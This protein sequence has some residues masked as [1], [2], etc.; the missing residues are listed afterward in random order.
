[1]VTAKYL[2]ACAADPALRDVMASADLPEAFAEAWGKYLLPRPMFC[3]ET[4]ARR[5]AGDLA[6]LFRLL[7]SL[8]D[9]LFGGDVRAFCAAL[10]MDERR[11][12][13][14]TRF[15]GEPILYG[16][17]D[18]YR[19]GSDFRLMEFNVGSE[20]GGVDV[21]EI[22][23]ALLATE[24]FRAFAD[25]HG[26]THV[27]TP[28]AI[29]RQFVRATGKDAPVVATLEGVDGIG[30]Y[31]ALHRSFQDAMRRQGIDLVYGEVDQVQT[32]DGRLHLH[33]KPVDLVLRY[34]SANQIARD[35]RNERPAGTVQRAHEDGRVVLWTPVSNGMFAYKSCLAML[36]GCDLPPDDRALVDRVLP[37]T[38]ALTPDLADRVRAERETVILKPIAGLSGRG[39]RAG[40]DHTDR[41]WAETVTE[42]L[43]EPYIAQRRIVPDREPVLD[44]GTGES[45]DWSAVWGV[46]AFPD[47]YGGAFCRAVPDS[48][49]SVVNL[50]TTGARVTS[51]LH[52]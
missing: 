44:P 24:P 18:L 19:E 31:E 48:G 36:S 14:M 11:I 7:T 39:I 30:A 13:I 52:H 6:G 49:G 42:C 45:T 21:S 26:L 41:E 25:D 10:G 50:G 20:L 43:R 3:D 29:A 1:M 35:A 17:A 51:V 27:D 4:A 5:A 23:P 28:A 12:D 32:R 38:R 47:G 34:Y 33:G 15:S 9:R 22:N 8:P 40:W 46:F 16:R 37:W 2:D